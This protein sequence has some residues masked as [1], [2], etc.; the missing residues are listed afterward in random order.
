MH[1]MDTPLALMMDSA[2]L[3]WIENGAFVEIGDK[4]G[5]GIRTI[6]ER[7]APTYLLPFTSSMDSTASPDKLSN[8]QHIPVIM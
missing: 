6:A 7:A 5:R 8:A 3:H 4:L 2:R 1:C